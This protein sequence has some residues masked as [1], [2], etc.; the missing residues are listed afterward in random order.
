MSYDSAQSVART[1]DYK[2]ILLVDS[3]I[4]TRRSSRWRRRRRSR[5]IRIFFSYL[6]SHSSSSS[7]GARRTRLRMMTINESSKELFMNSRRGTRE[8]W[9][10]TILVSFHLNP[11]SIS[12][13]VLVLV[14]EEEEEEIR[15]FFPSFF[16]SN[17]PWRA[18][19]RTRV[20]MTIKKTTSTKT[21]DASNSG[22]R[23]RI[24]NSQS[25]ARASALFLHLVLYF[26]L[27]MSF[28]SR[29]FFQES[30]L[31]KKRRKLFRTRACARM[32]GDDAVRLKTSPRRYYEL[33]RC[34][35]RLSAWFEITTEPKKRHE[36]EK[37]RAFLSAVLSV[38]L[39]KRRVG[40][41][42]DDKSVVS[43]DFAHIWV[44]D[45]L[46]NTRA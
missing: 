3:V 10:Q 23:K 39:L 20:M 32:F 41:S 34:C 18:R 29:C 15:K 27:C 44:K 19:A 37:T 6:M 16:F 31:E 21:T 9:S 33:R 24:L 12:S 2:S 14:G 8:R 36:R 7:R 42:D 11:K 26:F 22:W 45:G 35:C 40:V 38:S 28:L 46:Q 5:F 43:Y 25:R 13:H 17:A 30:S 4:W 1:G